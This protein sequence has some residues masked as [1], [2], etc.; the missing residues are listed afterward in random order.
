MHGNI[1]KYPMDPPKIME[2]G[3]HQMRGVMQTLVTHSRV[4]DN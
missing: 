3:V 4:S 2:G 1:E